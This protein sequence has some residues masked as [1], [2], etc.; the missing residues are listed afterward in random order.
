MRNGDKEEKIFQGPTT[1]GPEPERTGEP[2]LA[3]PALT[4]SSKKSQR[5][6]IAESVE[7]ERLAALDQ[8]PCDLCGANRMCQGLCIPM[9]WLLAG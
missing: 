7:A 9:D 1:F 3:L 6:E 5:F 2:P 4:E 8:G